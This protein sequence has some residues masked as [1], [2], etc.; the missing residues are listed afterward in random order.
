MVVVSHTGWLR[1]DPKGVQRQAEMCIEG[2]FWVLRERDNGQRKHVRHVRPT[3]FNDGVAVLVTAGRTLGHILHLS[4]IPTPE[5][6]VEGA[7]ARES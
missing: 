5:R 7:C 2:H 1:S 3:Q 6:L 4:R